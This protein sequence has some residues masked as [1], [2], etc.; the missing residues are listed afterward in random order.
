MMDAAAIAD[1]SARLERW[2]ARW[3]QSVLR[4]AK[5]MGG[6]RGGGLLRDGASIA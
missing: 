2:F 1:D 6:R 5:P 3:S 4:I